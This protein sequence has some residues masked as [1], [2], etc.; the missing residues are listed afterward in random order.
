MNSILFIAKANNIKPRC[1]IVLYAK[2]LF[3]LNCVKPKI[4][5]INR[6]NKELKSKLDPN[7]IKPNMVPI[8][9]DN[10]ELKSKLDLQLKLNG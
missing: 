4:V 10:K 8:I 9:R 7:K 6:D 3:I 5:P 1:K 2:S